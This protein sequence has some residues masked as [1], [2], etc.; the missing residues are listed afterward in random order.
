M[1]IRLVA[2]RTATSSATSYTS[3]NLDLQEEP[4]ISLNLQFSDIKEPETRK[5][6][7]SQTFKLPFTDTN[8]TFFEQWYNVNVTTLVYTTKEKFSAILYVGSVPQFEGFLQL[9][10]VYRKAR[11]YEVVLMSNTSDLFTVIGEKKLRDV[12]LNDDGLT[13]SEELNHVYNET[14]LEKSWDGTN[15][16]FENAAGQTLQDDTVDVNKVMYPMSITQPQFYFEAGS[17]QFLDMSQADINDTSLYPAGP[18]DA[19]AYM[20]SLLQFR[21][22]I[23]IK[24]LFQLIFARSGF[25]YT[26]AFIDGDYFGK[27]FMTTG[28]DL[29]AST[30]PTT[31]GEADFSG[32]CQAYRINS[33]GYYNFFPDDDCNDLPATTFIAPTIYSDDQNCW[34]ETN[35]AFT[36]KHPTQISM[37]ISHRVRIRDVEECDGEPMVMDVYLVAYDPVSDTE[38]DTQ[39]WALQ[40]DI[41]LPVLET[42]ADSVAYEYYTHWLDLDNLPIDQPVRI[43]LRPRNIHPIPSGTGPGEITSPNIV[44]GFNA[45]YG[46]GGLNAESW[47]QVGPWADYTVGLY[48]ATVDVPMCIDPNITQKAFL[49]DI[50]QRFNLIILSDPDDAT[51]LIIEP[52]NDY[53]AGGD[54]KDWT[55]KLDTSKEVIIKDTTSLQK[56]TIKFTDLEDDDLH[57][58][59]YRTQYPEVNVWGHYDGEITQNEFAKG[60]LKND[61]IFSPYIN[62]R[63]FP[64][65]EQTASD[66]ANMTVQY[67][68]S[69]GE[70]EIAVTDS[71]TKPK[72]FWYNG[73]P[74]T[75]LSQSGNT[76]TYYMHRQ[77]VEDLA[78]NA[79]SFT[80]YPV[81]SPFD[82]TP[83]GNEY[84]L[85]PTNKSLYWNANPPLS[86]SSI[87]VFN[88]TG[89]FG[90]WFDNALY[91]KYW[92]QYINN[93]YSDEARIM[94]A[95]INLN[96]VDI[97]NFKFN[98]EIFIQETYWRVLTISNYQ[99]GGKASTKVTLIKVIDSIN[100]CPGCGYVI[101]Y[102]SGGNNLY[103][104]MFY[105]WCPEGTPDCTPQTEYPHLGIYTD[106]DCCICMGGTP[107]LFATEYEDDGIYPCE[108]DGGSLPIKQQNLSSLSSLLGSGTLRNTVYKTIA[109]KNLPLTTG[110]DTTKYSRGILPYYGDDVVIKY[111]NK[112]NSTPQIKGESHRIVLMGNTEGNTRGY[113][114]PEGTLSSKPLKIPS[115]TNMIVR[116]KGIATVIGGTS[117]TYPVG[118]TEAFAYYTAFKN[119][120]DGVIQLSTAGG[121][122]EFSI[123]EGANP[124]T[125]TLY[126][127]INNG[128]L[129]FGLDDSQTDTQ[130]VWSLSVD[131]DINSIFNMY[132]G[133]NE[134]WALFQN[135]DY[136]YFEGGNLLIWN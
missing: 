37:Q 41:E 59:K 95:Y 48:D 17:S 49:K 94:E 109:G 111:K 134:N 8:N 64:N 31:T 74:T 5:A 19:Q 27:I 56:K 103:N 115:N 127:D 91:G 50:I 84:T 47:L 44:M 88:Y 54:M 76:I 51:N 42:P 118:T 101:G 114:Y 28:N 15:D 11:Y 7:Y 6:S 26:S 123:R 73:S 66:T 130:R 97:F 96:E 124:T 14:N 65:D 132:F 75:V 129:R 22:S 63:V 21:P 116:V 113:A 10:R 60:Q 1:K 55:H 98:D 20:V 2:Y 120:V 30:L 34:D 106:P 108:A 33:W 23:Q 46:P 61:P 105:L 90:S 81:C 136:I 62:D 92:Q 13:Y 102:D 57:N 72:L 128:I 125:C 18:V 87:T 85:S 135:G 58:K 78:I 112:R 104:G 36:K 71:T 43:K 131:L 25:K 69:Y 107:W 45:Q 100:N 52:Y 38:D 24:T 99:V 117:S 86:A 32:I 29:G 77:P 89:W 79:Y 12:F 68:F 9:K 80:T 121:Q 16:D 110:M 40:E 126:I 3:Y 39:I 93:I 83:S 53:L 67:E 122:S 70:D 35:Y 133:Y 4:N 119:T 82:I